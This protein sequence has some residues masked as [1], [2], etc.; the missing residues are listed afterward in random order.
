MTEGGAGEATRLSKRVAQQL[1]CSRATLY[2]DVAFLR[3]GGVSLH[4]P[5][6]CLL[7]DLRPWCRRAIHL[8]LWLPV[9]QALRMRPALIPFP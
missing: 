3:D 4:A 6:L 1:G 8:Q 7:G 5:E 2:R 9:R